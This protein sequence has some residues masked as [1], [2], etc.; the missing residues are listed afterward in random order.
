MIKQ[1]GKQSRE[2]QLRGFQGAEYTLYAEAS[3]TTV[4]EVLT[5]DASGYAKSSDLYYGMYYLKETKASYGYGLDET[6]YPITVSDDGQASVKVSSSEPRI[7]KP[8]ELQKYDQETGEAKPGNTALSF[9][10][11]QYTIYADAALSTPVE[12]LTLDETGHAKVRISN[13]EPTM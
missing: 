4:L 11:A 5:T 1:P 12:V 8:L 2:V 9:T 3:C 6:I 7:K 13:L 10:G